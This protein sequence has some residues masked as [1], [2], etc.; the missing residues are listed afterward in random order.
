MF[1]SFNRNIVSK[2]NRVRKLELN[3]QKKYKVILW[4]KRLQ[5]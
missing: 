2:T 5:N 1:C 3:Y 4:K